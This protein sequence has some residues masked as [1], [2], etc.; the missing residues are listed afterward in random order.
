MDH[1]RRGHHLG[2]EQR[3]PRQEPVQVPA[4]AIGPVHHRGTD[5]FAASVAAFKGIQRSPRGRQYVG[6]TRN[7]HHTHTD[8][9]AREEQAPRTEK[10]K[11]ERE[12]DLKCAG[13]HGDFLLFSWMQSGVGER[14][15]MQ[16]PV[17]LIQTPAFAWVG[18]IVRIVITS[19]DLC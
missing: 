1:R 19:L 2:I 8:Y 14:L 4:M 5:N 18:L 6:R 17:F 13:G 10:E 16:N 7:A 3:A 12:A 9:H 15:G 11:D